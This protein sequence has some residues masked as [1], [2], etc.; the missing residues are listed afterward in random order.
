MTVD[1][2]DENGHKVTLDSISRDDADKFH[3]E[4]QAT[5]P[6]SLASDLNILK[7][8]RANDVPSGIAELKRLIHQ[9]WKQCSEANKIILFTKLYYW[10]RSQ[11]VSDKKG[12]GDKRKVA[13]LVGPL[14]EDPVKP[15]PASVKKIDGPLAEEPPPK[16]AKTTST[17]SKGT[18]RGRGLGSVK[19]V[20]EKKEDK[21]SFSLPKSQQWQILPPNLSS[22][23]GTTSTSTSTTSPSLSLSPTP[24][25][26]TTNFPP[27][28]WSKL[29][30]VLSLAASFDQNGIIALGNSTNIQPEILAKVVHGINTFN[31]TVPLVF[32]RA[33]INAWSAYC[34]KNRFC[35][36]F[37]FF[38]IFSSSSFLLLLFSQ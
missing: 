3:K 9:E 36:F 20:K 25:G 19:E 8:E 5:F 4:H 18:L 22:S 14:G 37:F 13:D 15:E 1:T 12:P 11:N 28:S 23:S 27:P 30:F 29:T 32:S 26:T 21:E 24:T 35:F 31:I 2:V 7:S 38:L 33:L 17:P 34:Q 6:G 16:H 10:K